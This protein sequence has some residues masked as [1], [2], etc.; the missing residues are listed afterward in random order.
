MSKRAEFRTL[1][2]SDLSAA[3]GGF[4]WE[5]M[6][7]SNNIEDRRGMTPEESMNLPPE[8]LPPPLEIAPRFP[9]DLAS[10]LGVDDIDRR[11]PH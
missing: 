2:G 3:R 10:Q 6:P 4:K 7:R 8:P 5:Q 1:K 11:Y 9:G